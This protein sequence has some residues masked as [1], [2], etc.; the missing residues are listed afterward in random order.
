MLNATQSTR[1][2]IVMNISR[3]KYPAFS[4]GYVVAQSLP[5]HIV[6]LI[7]GFLFP[8]LFLPAMK[9]FIVAKRRQ[10]SVVEIHAY[11]ATRDRCAAL[12]AWSA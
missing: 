12:S 10:L 1:K 2:A 8:S 11:V 9:N 5:D 4:S 3:A 7:V 6:D